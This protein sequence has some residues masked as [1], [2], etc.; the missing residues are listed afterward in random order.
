[1]ARRSKKSRLPL[2]IVI[3]VVLIVAAFLGSRFFITTTSQ[4][5][6]TATPLDV[7]TYLENANSLRGNVYRMQGEV[8]N[9]LG[10]SSTKGRLIAVGVDNG[11]QVVPV[12]V[13]TDFSHI[14][15]QKGQKFIFLLEV[16]DKG[17]LRTKDM[18]KA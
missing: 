6:R 1:V 17:I 14:N 4:P 18:T 9:L 2:G 10:W 15:I 3:A 13:T 7:E 16:D 11:R 5:F 12:L 8:L